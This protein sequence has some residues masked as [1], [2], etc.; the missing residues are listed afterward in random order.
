MFSVVGRLR[1]HFALR[2]ILAVGLFGACF[3]CPAL[4]NEAPRPASWASAI[5]GVAG[6]GY[7]SQVE[8]ELYRSRQ[9]SPE[10]LRNMLAGKPLADGSSPIRTIVELRA[11][12]DVDGEVLGGSASVHHEWLRFNPFHPDD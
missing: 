2:C 7:L 4:A 5:S 12:R 3:L 9:P 10:A 8:P 11:L 1:G 6:M